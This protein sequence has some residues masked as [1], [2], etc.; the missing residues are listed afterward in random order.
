VYHCLFIDFTSTGHKQ[1]EINMYSS[2]S[3]LA[4]CIR[5]FTRSAADSNSSS[6]SSPFNWSPIS[7]ALQSNLLKPKSES[8]SEPAPPRGSPVS[9][10]AGSVPEPVAVS[11]EDDGEPEAIVIVYNEVCQTTKT[12][13]PGNL[14][15]QVISYPSSARCQSAPCWRNHISAVQR[16]AVSNVPRTA[17]G[18]TEQS[19]RANLTLCRRT[20]CSGA[21][22]VIALVPVKLHA[23]RILLGAHRAGRAQSEVRRSGER[24]ASA[25]HV[26]PASCLTEQK[27]R[28]RGRGQTL[29]DFTEVSRD[30]CFGKNEIRGAPCVPYHPGM[31][32]T[33][34][35]V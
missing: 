1:F 9:G 17:Q 2:W 26:E 18:G 33:I 10:L 13:V 25:P 15:Q 3:L 24:R 21:A 8:E 4:V 19:H 31:E 14:E 23:R 29:A 27:S 22:A 12:V 28:R 7:I 11:G 30:T 6:S 34:S 16:M 5:S 35:P 20:T 32:E